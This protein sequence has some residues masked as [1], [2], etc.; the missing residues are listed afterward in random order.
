VQHLGYVYV[1]PL[2][3]ALVVK[4]DPGSVHRLAAIAAFY[5]IAGRAPRRLI[6]ASLE[7][8]ND[9]DRYEIFSTISEGLKRL[10]AAAEASPNPHDQSWGSARRDGTASN[11]VPWRPHGLALGKLGGDSSRRLRLPLAVCRTGVY[12]TVG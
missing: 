3:D 4:F 2:R 10:E 9:P 5:E 1:V 8:P 11:I 7:K 6:L 12:R